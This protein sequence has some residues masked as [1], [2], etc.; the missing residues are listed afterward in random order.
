MT[1]EQKELMRLRVDAAARQLNEALVDAH[2]FGLRSQVS[3]QGGEDRQTVRVAL[4][5]PVDLTM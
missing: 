1:E 3:P 4:M 5:R 2:R